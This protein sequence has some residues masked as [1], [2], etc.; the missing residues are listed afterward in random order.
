M[1]E[2]QITQIP[3]ILRATAESLRIR[4]IIAEFVSA[5]PTTSFRI[6]PQISDDR[7]CA[8]CGICGSPYGQLVGGIS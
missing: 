7:I 2:P 3:P 6:I 4:E 5:M 8:I 1:E